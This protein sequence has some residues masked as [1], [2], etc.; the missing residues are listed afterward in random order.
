MTCL[1]TYATLRIF[2]E[3]LSPDEIGI[4]LG[5]EATQKRP[6]D[7]SS[8][9]KSARET[10]YWNLCTRASVDSRDNDLH[11]QAMIKLLQP[12]R[13]ALIKLQG[14]GCQADI[15][16]YWVSTGQGGPY[17]SVETMRLLVDLKL[18]VW[19]DMCLG[20]ESEYEKRR[21]SVA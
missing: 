16:N 5:V 18:P 21:G 9:F 7:L 3:T 14:M 17:L 2:S 10:N 12:H 4:I 6:R 8:R 20:R 15:V 13:D 1:E 19:W 11:L